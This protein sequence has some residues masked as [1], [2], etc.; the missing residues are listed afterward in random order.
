MYFRI[1][2]SVEKFEGILEN[3]VHTQ[4][5]YQQL[6]EV[7]QIEF[8]QQQ[9]SS[10][11]RACNYTFGRTLALEV[12]WGNTCPTQI[13][14][15]HKILAIVP[16]EKYDLPDCVEYGFQIESTM[17]LEILSRNYM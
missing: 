15:C 17:T 11:C 3:F 10:N 8:T 1:Q 4:S 13:E 5:G 6:T 16:T 9:W 7:C 14:A 12:N 2:D